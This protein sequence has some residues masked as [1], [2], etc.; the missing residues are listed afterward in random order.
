MAVWIRLWNVLPPRGF[1]TSHRKQVASCDSHEFALDSENTTTLGVNQK[2]IFA[3]NRRV[4]L[5]HWHN[6]I[7]VL[8]S[9]QHLATVSVDMHSRTENWFEKEKGRVHENTEICCCYILYLPLI[10]RSAFFFFIEIY[11][12]LCSSWVDKLIYVW[13]ENRACVLSDSVCFLPI[14]N[15]MLVLS[16]SAVEFVRRVFR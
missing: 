3:K 14:V 1:I 15:C 12:L 16:R 2:L 13:A 7:H 5:L 9:A 8:Q 6:V 11:V 10:S 4:Y